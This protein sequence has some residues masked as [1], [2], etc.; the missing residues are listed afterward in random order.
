MKVLLYTSDI[1]YFTWFLFLFLLFIDVVSL[2]FIWKL[3]S[4]SAFLQ[5]CYW[6]WF[7][8]IS[9]PLSFPKGTVQKVLF[10]NETQI[11]SSADFMLWLWHILLHLKKWNFLN[12]LLVST[13]V[14]WLITMQKAVTT[15]SWIITTLSRVYM[16]VGMW[17]Q[18]NIVCILF[19][20]TYFPCGFSDDCNNFI[21][22]GSHY[23]HVGEMVVHSL[24]FHQSLEVMV[25]TPT[26]RHFSWHGGDENK[27]HKGVKQMKFFCKFWCT[28]EVFPN[29]QTKGKYLNQSS[30]RI[31]Q[32]WGQQRCGSAMNAFD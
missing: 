10:H 29:F 32:F 13:S 27:K 12:H 21:L 4:G 28:E 8:G 5:K 1:W 9:F 24:C 20:R 3:R 30:E 31:W 26:S 19:G 25:F 7:S 15:L 11:L 14:I 6:L 18:R 17:M 2:G 22:D 23:I 16:W